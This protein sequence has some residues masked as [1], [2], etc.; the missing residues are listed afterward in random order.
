MKH[1]NYKI[2]LASLLFLIIF[3]ISS[4]SSANISNASKSQS[5]I[6]NVTNNIKEINLSDQTNETEISSLKKEDIKEIGP[7]G[8]INKIGDYKPLIER[9][10]I[11][12]EEEVEMRAS[13]FKLKGGKNIKPFAISNKNLINILDRREFKNYIEK[14]DE[15]LPVIIVLSN[16]NLDKISNELKEDFREKIDPRLK[17]IEDIESKSKPGMTTSEDVQFEETSSIKLSKKDIE[18]INEIAKDIDE[19]LDSMKREIISKNKKEI[20]SEQNKVKQ[21]I[22]DCNG[23]ITGDSSII[24]SIFA[25]VN[26]S[27]LEE[28]AKNKEVLE[29]YED[30][31][32]DIKLN[33]ATCAV[34]ATTWYYY[35]YDG[36]IWD[37]A[38]VDSGIDGDHP[39]LEVDYAEVFHDSGRY[40][41][42][43]DD[44]YTTTDDL[45]GHGTHCAGIVASEDSKYRGEGYGI[46]DLINVKAGW[47]PGSMYNSDMMM[48]VE[49]AINTAGADVISYSYGSS[50]SQSSD[51][52]SCRFFDAVVDDLGVVVSV[53]AGNDGPSSPSVGTPA[54]AYN[55]FSVAAL[56]DKNNC[57]QS[58]DEIASYSS[59]GPT[60]DGRVKPDITAPGHKIRSTNAFWEGIPLWPSANGCDWGSLTNGW[61]FVDNCGTSMAAPMVA[62]SIPLILDYKGYRWDPKAIRA[63]I[64]NTA[65]NDGIFSSK[66]TYGWGVLDM[67]N[68]YTHKDDVF[69]DSV[70]EGG[71]KLYKGNYMQSGDK[72][73]LVWNRHVVYNGENYPTEYYSL[74]DLDLKLYE[75]NTGNLI[76]SS[77]TSADNVEQIETSSYYQDIIVKVD[78]FSLDFSHNLDYEQ[79]ALATEEGFYSLNGPNINIELETLREFNLTDL[80]FQV[81]VSVTNN[82]DIY[83][84][85]LE[86]V[87]N[88]PAGLYLDSGTYSKNIGKIQPGQ[89]INDQW[90]I[91]AYN[92]GEYSNI[93]IT[94]FGNLFGEFETFE[95]DIVSVDILEI[96]CFTNLDCGNTTINNYCSWKDSCQ[97]IIEP[98]CMNPGTEESYCYENFSVSCDYCSGGCENGECIICSNN[99]NCNDNNLSTIDKC[100]NPGTNLSY[101][102]YV[103]DYDMPVILNQQPINNSLLEDL[104]NFEIEYTE[105]NLNNVYLGFYNS[106]NDLEYLPIEDVSNIF[107]DFA[108]NVTEEEVEIINYT[109]IDY[110][111]ELTFVIG[112]DTDAITGYMTKDGKYYSGYLVNI[113]DT[114]SNS[115]VNSI[116]NIVNY[117]GENADDEFRISQIIGLGYLNEITVLLEDYNVSVYITPDGMYYVS[118][119]LNLEEYLNQE[120]Q[121]TA[122]IQQTNSQNLF[123]EGS[124]LNS[125]SGDENILFLGYIQEC[126]SGENL[127]CNFDVNFIDYSYS[128]ISYE[129]AL[130]DESGKIIFGDKYNLFDEELINCS[131]DQEC[132]DFNDYTIDSCLNPGTLDSHCSYEDISCIVDEDCKD[133]NN[134]TLDTCINPNQLDSYCLH[135][136]ITCLSDSDCGED[137]FEENNSF[138]LG[139]NIG[140]N[141]LTHTCENQGTTQSSCILSYT[142][143]EVENCSDICW[144]GE[145]VERVCSTDDEC[146]DSNPYT[147]DRCLN[148]D[149][150]Y[151]SCDYEDII[152]LSNLDCN[153]SEITTTGIC[154]YAGTTQSYCENKLPGP[155]LTINSPQIDIS[156]DRRILLDLETT[157]EVDEIIY[158]YFDSRGR[159]RERRL[160][161]NCDEYNRK[162]SFS[163]GY[164]ELTFKAIVD[165]EVVDEKDVNF[166]IDYKD[167]RISKTEPSRG[168]SDG[169][170]YVEFKE[171]NPIS[172]VLHYG[173]SIRTEVLNL[174]EDCEEER[175]KSKCNV[176]VNLSDFDNKEIEYWFEIEDIAGNTDESR[177]REVDVDMTNPIL[178]NPDSFWERGIGRYSSYI[179]FDLSITEINFDEAVLSYDYRGRTREKRLCSRL[180]Y[181]SCEKKFRIRDDYSNMKVIIRD[182]AGN[183]IEREIKL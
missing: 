163:S 49:W 79:F 114:P 56:D 76:D 42:Y 66:N 143:T 133:S 84:D 129:F 118:S 60:Y 164:N 61:N 55:V 64:Y 30:E 170:F 26:L 132:N 106:E 95:S 52:A 50:Y 14:N 4:V 24:N 151:A 70:T 16:Q 65:N 82:G 40:S 158:T 159:E 171:D 81:N 135:V 153:D 23:I 54:I 124:N 6:L 130:E 146:N 21:K 140:K 182:D 94:S 183:S 169:N 2:V 19:D 112:N 148:P 57:D 177:K 116:Q 67:S 110:F 71:Y 142:P 44:D 125:L 137:G 123:N 78:S 154:H 119:A 92:G 37:V 5:E 77:T 176:W 13:S 121:T 80:P 59:R 32:M 128:I 38:I 93:Y 86:L 28:L 18:D 150:L 131:V 46:D 34:G 104:M 31:L 43:Y 58:D 27:C 7:K 51:C 47:N 73:T 166:T 102:D 136:N 152:C 175:G 179:Y 15:Q 108:E 113:S 98:I 9:L 35:G 109:E 144:D 53:S 83:L 178:N 181:G 22:K 180:R 11:D 25:R 165:D 75:E 41:P 33:D 85:D 120:T 127:F 10:G 48:G 173:N 29:I 122:S 72:A 157:D 107:I 87:L 68:A 156:D 111:Y 138:C 39:A 96:D 90:S 62:G 105:Q 100:I 167:P 8:S 115:W 117:I 141:Y 91:T 147:E 160:C 74:N 89:T 155:R 161:R 139:S 69:L 36:G 162:R 45:N 172:L 97:E 1:K 149:W 99:F 174:S 20:S 103:E 3:M 101:C 134:Y 17:A 12:A 126:P 63:L 168:F 145:C 88:L